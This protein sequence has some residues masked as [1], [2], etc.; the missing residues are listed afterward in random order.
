MRNRYAI[1]P[2]ALAAF[3]VCATNGFSAASIRPVEPRCE[4]HV[5]PQGLDVLQPRLSWRLESGQRAQ[6]QSAYRI[7]V[8]GSPETL[9]NDAG[10]LWDS[11]KVN[12]GESIQ[13]AYKGKP[14]TS[15]QSCCWK[16]MVWDREGNPSIWSEPAMWSMGLLKPK[17]WKAQWI[18]YDEIPEDPIQEGPKVVVVKAL[19][20]LGG[21]PSKQ[22][23]VTE[24]LQKRVA[25]GT[26]KLSVGNELAEKDPAPGKLKKLELEYTFDGVTRKRIFSEGETFEFFS[27]NRPNLMNRSYLP[28]PYLR[29]VFAVKAPVK[30]AVVYVSAQGFVELHL[31]GQRVGD[32]FFTPPGWTDYRKRIYYKAYDVT[33]LLQ[34]GDNAIGGILGDGWF[35]GNISIKGQNQYGSKIRLLSQ[36]HIDYADGRS[37]TVVSDPSWKAS[38]G[39]I[40]LS[41]MQAGETYDARR[42]MPG[43]DKS[44]FDDSQWRAVNTGSALKA[45]P[46]IEAYP[47]VPVRRTQELPVV[48][49][50]EPMKGL[51]VFDLGQNFAGWV[52]LKVSGKAGDKIVMR[53]GEMLS[54][55]GS[56]FTENLRSARAT[57]TYILKG[58]GVEVW[59]P[60]FTFHGFRYVEVTGLR[61][62]PPADTLTGVV[63]HS[64]A[65]LTSSFE[66]SDPMLNQ[67]HSN[68]LW[69]QRSN[70]LEVPTDCPQRDERL[71]WTG[72]TQVYIRSGTYHQDVASFFTKWIVDLEDTQNRG[73]FGQ[74]AP[75]FH[76]HAS[77]G[78]SDAGIICPWTIYRVYGD[79][80]IVEK[81]YDAMARYIEA[82]EKHGLSGI[83]KGFGD[84]LAVGSST[85]KD[86]ISTA[87][88]AYSTSLMAEMAEAIGKK[89]DATTYRELFERIRE[90][91]QKT[92]VD[93]DGRVKG[94][95]QTAYC[96]ALHYDL[97]TEK[98]RRQ[99]AAHL[100][101]RIKAKDYHLS[102]GFLGVPILLPTL[103]EIGR[104]DLAYRLLQNKTYPSWGYS[105]EQGATT[106]WERWDSWTREKGFNAGAMNSFNHYAYGACSEWMFYSMLGID[107][108]AAG[109]KTIRMKPEIGSGITWAKGHYDSIRGRISSDWKIEDDTFH[110]KVEIPANSTATMYIAAEQAADVTEGGRPVEDGAGIQVLGQKEGCVVIQVGSGSYAFTAKGRL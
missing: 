65:P 92:F 46:V 54:P 56:V 104:S 52:R 73:M 48:K 70:Y 68:I 58:D 93:A 51:H 35:R 17:D 94:N 25:E 21:K 38:F 3:I 2:V 43:W 15:R 61:E 97:L 55:D 103:T 12:S 76:G 7:L 22:V 69:G 8:A 57:D 10:D 83:P 45:N 31:N 82:C 67:L 60:H 27:T 110:W 39:P 102:V 66:C 30:R 71:G 29:K 101:E 23:D 107:L 28:S 77:S 62:D 49:I 84:W 44:G 4:Y 34:Q 59:E 19:Y 26:L 1:I 24:K 42:E 64:D 81:H 95:T 106:I 96:M 47:G 11:G 79:A 75:A 105:V 33:D 36:L 40:L 5:E 89:A 109:Y 41:D 63:V 13:I 108:D 100:V 53:F 85:P 91:F 32:E 88:F 80:R 99:A 20:G 18:G 98:Q 74:Q 9:A 72:D 37:E 87:Y 86:V 14:L 50:T 78:W 16:V 90:H 6:M